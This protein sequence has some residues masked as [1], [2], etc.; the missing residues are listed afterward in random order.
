[1]LYI[2]QG[3]KPLPHQGRKTCSARRNRSDVKQTVQ[4]D[5]ISQLPNGDSAQ[6]GKVGKR[7]QKIT[8]NEGGA[9]TADEQRGNEKKNFIN[10][11]CP[12]KG[13]MNPG[14]AFHQN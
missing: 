13:C 10:K 12:Q 8:G 4:Q 2:R 14:A 1:M 3:R 7:K 9:L 6:S 5:I 11:P